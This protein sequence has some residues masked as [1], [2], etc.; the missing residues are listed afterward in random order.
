MGQWEP[1]PAAQ[2]PLFATKALLELLPGQA[3]AG[4]VP[5]AEGKCQ[6]LEALLGAT[7]SE[8]HGNSAPRR[9]AEGSFGYLAG[10][11]GVPVRYTR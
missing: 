4:D 3:A 2:A 10:L 6:R 11:N 1:A 9:R 8:E 5:A 7:G